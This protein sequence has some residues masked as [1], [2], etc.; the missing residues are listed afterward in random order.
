MSAT[1]LLLKPVLLLTVL[2]QFCCCDRT[3]RARTKEN[4]IFP[5]NAYQI[6]RKLSDTNAPAPIPPLPTPTFVPTTNPQPIL[7][8]I[9]KI[10]KV[11][12]KLAANK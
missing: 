11:C 2:F 12:L 9:C 1:S 6:S 3:L 10:P 7:P 4:K 8:S 5:S